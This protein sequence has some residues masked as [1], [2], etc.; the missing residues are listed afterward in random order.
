[1]KVLV[2]DEIQAAKSSVTPV[3]RVADQDER[4]ISTSSRVLQTASH[5]LGWSGFVQFKDSMVFLSLCLHTDSRRM[6]P[7]TT[8]LA[9][10]TESITSSGCIFHVSLR[11]TVHNCVREPFSTVKTEPFQTLAELEIRTT[12]LWKRW[13]NWSNTIFPARGKNVPHH[14]VS[15][16]PGKTN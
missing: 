14:L 12:V 11:I 2:Q 9:P 8:H 6:S 16:R 10:L 13:K 1:M 15:L 5:Q 3:G 7:G 4:R